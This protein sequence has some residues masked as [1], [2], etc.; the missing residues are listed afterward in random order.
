VDDGG[1]E[2]A[3]MGSPAPTEGSRRGWA[4]ME[5]QEGAPSKMLQWMEENGK[6][7]KMVEWRDGML[8]SK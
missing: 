2:E 1:P 8:G 3:R 6:A 7:L 4:G 5:G